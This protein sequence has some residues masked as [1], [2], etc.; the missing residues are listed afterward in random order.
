M[1]WFQSTQRRRQNQGHPFRSSP[2]SASLRRMIP[3]VIS[4][5]ALAA[6]WLL[7][8]LEVEPIPTWFYVAAW[9]PTL[10]VLDGIASLLGRDRPLLSR[11]QLAASLFLWSP[12]LWLLFEAVNFRLQ[13]WYYVFLPRNPGERWLGIVVSFATVLPAVVLAERFVARAGVGRRWQSRPL[14]LGVPRVEWFVPLGVVATA[15]A[16]LWPRWMHPLVWGSFLLI[17]DP[18]VYRRNP[19][20]SLLADLEHGQWGRTGRLMLGGAGIGLLWE[21][22]NHYARGKWIYTVPWLEDTKWF[23]MPPL[24]FVGFPFF[25]LEAWSLYHALAALRVAVPVSQQ[26]CPPILSLRRTL[27]AAVLAATFALTALWGMEHRTI[28]STV[29]LLRIGSTDVV[30]WEVAEAEPSELA[31]RFG[32]SGDSAAAL[33][34]TATIASLRGIGL[35]HALEL[36]AAGVTTV[37]ELAQANPRRLWNLIHRTR[38]RPGIRPTEAEARV[39][40]RAAAQ[41]CRR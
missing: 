23:E 12:V 19:E 34:E 6:A 38:A 14:P 41:K 18:L 17:A 5:L 39:W 37:C 29:P 2:E 25:A 10:F 7:L 30:A 15:A 8:G 36:K 27:L 33:V 22:Y 9:Y 24:G 21:L 13:T 28:S 40:V 4:I 1:P 35:E 11:S 26:T 3:V 20:L 16:L 31:Q 32:I